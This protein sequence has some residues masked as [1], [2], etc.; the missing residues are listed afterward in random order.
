MLL[1]DTPHYRLKNGISFK[2]IQASERV[3]PDSPQ[4]VGLKI[5]KNK[6][7]AK[8]GGGLVLFFGV[9]E[10]EAG[11]GGGLARLLVGPT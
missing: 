1:L 8:K 4:I 11:E 9:G 2:K 6:P 10:F 3:L 7:S 5:R